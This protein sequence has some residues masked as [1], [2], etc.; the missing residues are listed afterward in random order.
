MCKEVPGITVMAMGKIWKKWR[1]EE[2]EE[3]H[4]SRFPRS[5]TLAGSSLGYQGIISGSNIPCRVQSDV[6][7][8]LRP[9]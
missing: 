8:N 6:A 7:F 5:Y 2:E 4:G 3:R 1:A 9:G